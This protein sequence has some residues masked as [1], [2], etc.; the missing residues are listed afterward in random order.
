MDSQN[1]NTLHMPLD[2]PIYYEQF[3]AIS[4]AVD[5]KRNAKGI[6]FAWKNNKCGQVW[7][8]KGYISIRVLNNS[9]Q[10]AL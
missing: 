8:A 7:Q 5:L 4:S 10:L 6:I 1:L 2:L 9:K 3:E